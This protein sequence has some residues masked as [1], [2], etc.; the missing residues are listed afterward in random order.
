MHDV[1]FCKQLRG[2]S[3]SHN[4][5]RR[6]LDFTPKQD[7]PRQY[8]RSCILLFLPLFFFLTFLKGCGLRC[9]RESFWSLCKTCFLISLGFV[10]VINPEFQYNHRVATRLLWATRVYFTWKLPPSRCD[11]PV[12]NFPR[13][14]KWNCYLVFTQMTREIQ[15][16]KGSP[17]II[18]CWNRL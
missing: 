11:N 4:A 9:Y 10:R 5:A 6:Q 12:L 1:H 3:S 7:W 16:Q 13:P 2:S 8:S 18:F 14:V 17:T 15:T